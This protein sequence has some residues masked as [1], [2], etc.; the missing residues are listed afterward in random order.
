[1]VSMSLTARTQPIIGNSTPDMIKDHFLP[2]AKKLKEASVN[3]EYYEKRLMIDK[4][5]TSDSSD[6]EAV[7][8]EVWVPWFLSDFYL[9][10]IEYW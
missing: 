4:R 10:K 6:M 9:S 2:I 5:S 8:Q 1:M 7:V 3:V